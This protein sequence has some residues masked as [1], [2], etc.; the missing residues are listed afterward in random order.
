MLTKGALATLFA[1]QVSAFPWVLDTIGQPRDYFGRQERRQAMPGSAATCP[2]NPNHKGAVPIS[3]KYPYCG[4]KNGLPGFQVCVN[5]LV[6]AKVSW[7]RVG[8]RGMKP[9]KLI[10]ILSGRHCSLLHSAR[11]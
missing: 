1:A 6:P 4:A 10:H 9:V 8:R 5:N 7:A 11:T 2:N 3:A